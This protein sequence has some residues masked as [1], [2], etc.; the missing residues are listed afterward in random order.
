[1]GRPRKRRR[2]DGT[3]EQPTEY[4][5]EAV[6]AP[7]SVAVPDFSNISLISPDDINDFSAYA[8]FQTTGALSNTLSPLSYT[9]APLETNFSQ[10]AIPDLE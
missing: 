2:E 4:Q 5:P 10:P 7:K 6:S 1:M 8:D 3:S 9:E